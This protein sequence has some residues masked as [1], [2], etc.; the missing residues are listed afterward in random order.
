MQQ[1][2][3]KEVLEVFCTLR[4]QFH[5][6]TAFFMSQDTDDAGVFYYTQKSSENDI[7]EPLRK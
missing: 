4:G 7:V 5:N 6:T 2:H 3:R 1:R